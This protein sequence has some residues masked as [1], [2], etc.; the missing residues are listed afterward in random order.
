ML[1][2][3]QGL[4]RNLSDGR[5][6]A[7]ALSVIRGIRVIRVEPLQLRLGWRPVRQPNRSFATRMRRMKAQVTLFVIIRAASRSRMP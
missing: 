7:S 2:D 1:R 5:S 3:A 4:A 6:I